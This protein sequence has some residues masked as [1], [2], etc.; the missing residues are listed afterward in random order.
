MLADRLTTAEAAA[1]DAARVDGVAGRAT[2]I[3]RFYHRR[4]RA[5]R[6]QLARL[7]RGLRGSGVPVTTLPFCFVGE[8]G[9][10]ELA[11]IGDRLDNRRAKGHAQ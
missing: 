6:A 5:Q 3:A 1:L 10:T 9:A 2:R 11:A 7:R 8:L 4:A